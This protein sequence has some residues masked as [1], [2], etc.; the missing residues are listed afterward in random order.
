MFEERHRPL[1]VPRT[2]SD[3]VT[4]KISHLTRLV[5]HDH[6]QSAIE[7]VIEL[8]YQATL[9]GGMGGGKGL[10]ICDHYNKNKKKSLFAR[11]RSI[12]TLR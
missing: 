11:S 9:C 2:R 7:C 5:T 4:W 10:I 12:L 1:P 6:L 3:K 8:P